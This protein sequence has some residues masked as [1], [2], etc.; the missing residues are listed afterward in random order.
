LLLFIAGGT[1][2][3]DVVA[4][5]VESPQQLPPLIFW[6]CRNAPASVTAPAPSM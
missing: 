1:A 3:Q 2:E 6:Q 4:L 5:W